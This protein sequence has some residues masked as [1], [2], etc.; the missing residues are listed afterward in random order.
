[1]CGFVCLSAQENHGLQRKTATTTVFIASG[2]VRK[3]CK[4][5]ISPNFNTV[6]SHFLFFQ[7][8]ERVKGAYGEV[9]NGL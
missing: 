6:L 5:S 8:V 2:Y 4:F 9:R 7:R 3:V 1:M